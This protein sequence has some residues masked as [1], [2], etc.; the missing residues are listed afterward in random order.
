[1]V[2]PTR[3]TLLFGLLVAHWS[4]EFAPLPETASRVAR[5][6]VLAVETLWFLWDH[7]N[8]VKRQRSTGDSAQE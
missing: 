3:R 8:R 7:L 6:I 1:M 5:L 4:A 2:A